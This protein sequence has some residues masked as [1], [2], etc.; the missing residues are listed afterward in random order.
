MEEKKMAPCVKCGESKGKIKEC[1]A[2]YT[3]FCDDC[4]PPN[5]I[6]KDGMSEIINC[7]PSCGGSDVEYLK[8][9]MA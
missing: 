6:K 7:C 4:Y 5:I 3:F 9:M 1:L 2:C 8:I